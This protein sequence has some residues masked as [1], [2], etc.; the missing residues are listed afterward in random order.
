MALFTMLAN[1][2]IIE[3]IDFKASNRTVTV[4]NTNIRVSELQINTADI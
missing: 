2:L 3:L 1:K 4:D